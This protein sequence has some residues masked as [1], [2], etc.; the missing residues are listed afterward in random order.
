MHLQ[1]LRM[2]RHRQEDLTVKGR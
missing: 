2:G 1:Y